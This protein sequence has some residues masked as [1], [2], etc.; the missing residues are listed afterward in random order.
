MIRVLVWDP[1]PLGVPDTLTVARAKSAKL[2]WN[3]HMTISVFRVAKSRVVS[4]EIVSE[5]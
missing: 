5:V 3:I 1:C 2:V 4:P